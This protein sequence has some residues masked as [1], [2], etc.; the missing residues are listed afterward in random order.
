LALIA[1]KTEAPIIPAYIIRDKMKFRAVFGNEIPLIKT[2]N[3][4]E[5]VEANT[6][7]YNNII[8][9]FIR[10]YPDQW[11]WIHRRWKNKPPNPEQKN[12]RANSMG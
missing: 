1:L 4:T 12:T 5:D 11:F 3:K 8:E 2:G 9:G 6:L 10:R 7:Q